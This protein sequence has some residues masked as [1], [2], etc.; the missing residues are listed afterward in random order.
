MRLP[1]MA[2]PA[3]H[4]DSHFLTLKIAVRTAAAYPVLPLVSIA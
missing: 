1:F 3:N 2:G 4:G